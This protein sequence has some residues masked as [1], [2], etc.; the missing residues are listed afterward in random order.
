MPESQSMIMAFFDGAC[1]PINPGGHM[2]LGWVIDGTKYCDHVAAQA[3]NSNNV[4]EY[5]ALIRLLE[6]VSTRSPATLRIA[7]DSQL[8]VNQIT[9]EW[10]MHSRNLATLCQDATHLID[11]LRSSGWTV[12]LEWVPREEN[13]LADEAS[14]RAL[15]DHGV[16]AASRTPTPGFVSRLGDLGAPRGLS[17]IMVGK[18]LVE[19]GLR[20]ADKRPTESAFRLGYVRERFDGYSLVSDWNEQMVG[21]ALDAYTAKHP[22]KRS[23]KDLFQGSAES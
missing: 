4:A 9:G 12:S 13:L 2:G 21:A 1:E 11:K 20:G 22:V 16:E 17:A 5:S 10:A 14:K 6:A 3:H 15:K 18:L 19:L 8:V 7:G 23:R